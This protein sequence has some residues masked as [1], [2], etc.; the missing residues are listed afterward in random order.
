MVE[1]G[2]F[3][4]AELDR[5]RGRLHHLTVVS[6]SPFGRRGP[7]ADRP[8]TEFT[9]QAL[10]GSTA[11]RGTKDREPLHAGGRLGEWI[12]G[13]Y[14]AVGALAGLRTARA[15]GAGE[16]VDVALL[17]CMAITMGGYG[18]AQRQH[19]RQGPRRGRPAAWRP[20]R[21]SRRPTATSASA[22]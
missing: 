14:A 4:V 7:W 19:E 1:S 9:L 8:A 13:V 16:H 6:I 3:S 17:E 18:T 5:I 15:S 11:N 10:C 2:R 21:S 12:G 20:R 22:R